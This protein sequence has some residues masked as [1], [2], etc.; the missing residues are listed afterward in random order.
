MIDL[1]TTPSR[2]QP[3]HAYFFTVL[4]LASTALGLNTFAQT[5]TNALSKE[6]IIALKN[7]GVS[8]SVLI[9]Q[10]QKDGINFEMNADA[11]LEL[12]NSGVSNEVLQALLTA[13]VDRMGPAPPA[14]GPEINAR[15][16]ELYKAGKYGELADYLKKNLSANP[17]DYKSRTFLILSLL[18]LKDDASANQEFSELKR[19]SQDP[20]ARRYV[21]KVESVFALLEKQKEGKSKI[22]TALKNFNAHEA[23]TAIEQLPASP[24]QREYLNVILDSYSGNFDSAH[25][26]LSKLNLESFAAKQQL[27]A[28]DDRVK[29]AQDEYTKA[30][31]KLDVYIHSPLA[32]SSCFGP[33]G[34]WNHSDYYKLTVAEY[35]NTVSTLVKLV[36]LNDLALNS[37]F[38][39]EMLVGDYPEVENVGDRMLTAKGDIR[40]PFFSK[41]KYFDVVIDGKKRRIYSVASPLPFVVQYALNG[42]GI[43]RHTGSADHNDWNAALVP[44]DLSFAEITSVSQHVPWGHTTA[45]YI[46]GRP[47]VLKFSPAGQA[48]NYAVMLLLGCTAGYEAQ[49]RATRNLGQY[50][51]H[52][53]G[54]KDLSAELVDPSKKPSNYGWMLGAM[55]AFYGGVASQTGNTALADANANLQQMISTEQAKGDAIR[56]QQMQTASALL[57]DQTAFLSDDSFANLESLLGLL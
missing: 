55:T 33:S 23:S 24:L 4:I 6:K 53:I 49:M 1:R 26:R 11:T 32:P 52:V 18:K 25:A 22:L 29:Q 46:K 40:L 7:A 20:N 28:I 37:L 31:A 17:S 2:L 10:I 47:Y 54:R 50:V 51:V 56:Q 5:S 35:L 14:V 9:Q 39:A 44:F 41:D 34:A 38:H 42:S 30:V 13:K 43:G 16:Q 45:D 3:I 19:R 15:A 57:D 27:K 12:K 36:P 8:D 48:P 21:E